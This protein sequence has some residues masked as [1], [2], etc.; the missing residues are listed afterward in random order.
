MLVRAENTMMGQGKTTRRAWLGAVLAL[1]LAFALQPLSADPSFAR[2][3]PDSFAD[4]AERLSPAVVNI[5][6]SQTVSGRNTR[7]QVPGLPEGSP[8]EDFFEDF[9]ERQGR[10]GRAAPRSVAR[11]RFCRRSIRLRD[12]QQPCD[13]RRR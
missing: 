5:S 1:A 4:L 8:F 9:L 3:A 10:Q 2:G 11:F 13:R 12:Y 7:Q 6:T